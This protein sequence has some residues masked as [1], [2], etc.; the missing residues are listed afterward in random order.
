LA[1]ARK[2]LRR[3]LVRDAEDS[4]E[5]FRPLAQLFLTVLNSTELL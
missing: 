3:R 4:L 1:S 5:Q 2:A